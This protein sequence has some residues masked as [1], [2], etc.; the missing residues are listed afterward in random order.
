[1]TKELVVRHAS[2]ME[3]QPTRP[4]TALCACLL[5]AC[6]APPGAAPDAGSA[7]DA[8]TATPTEF[9][10]TVTNGFG[11]GNYPAGA[12]V[13]VWSDHDPRAQIVTRWSGDV[14]LLSDS[15][16]WHTSL[17]MPAR[18]VSL[19]AELTDS[20][21]ELVE[22]QFRGRDRLKTVRY[23]I[24]P[25]P[26]GMVHITHGTGGS[27]AII[28]GIEAGYIARVLVHAGYGVWATDAEEVDTGDQDGN[29]KIRWNVR[30]TEDNVDF[31]NLTQIIE[32]FASRELI[33]QGTPQFIVGM[34]NGGAFA[35]VAGS[36]LNLSAAVVYCA[37]GSEGVAATTETP[38]AWF[39]CEQ[40]ENEQV[41]NAK[42]ARNHEALTARGVPSA[43]S[44]HG[45]SPLYDQRFARIVGIDAET[46]R[47]IAS[48]LRAGG[49]TDERDFL[50]HDGAD[51]E[52]RVTAAPSDYPVIS[53]LR[54]RLKGLEVLH[55]LR[56]L[57]SNHRLYDDYARRTLTFLQAHT[58]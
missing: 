20:S 11:S 10:L 21:F 16:E 5:A 31:A 51:I 18:D 3:T 29:D 26:V 36:A 6:A 19:Q 47:A 44:S 14:A 38:T 39:L 17:V 22:A 23:H 49:H 45:P 35:L 1:L 53:G 37:S 54:P 30:P 57:R 50:L 32:Q 41:D 46:S 9:Q 33:R 43:L 28:E 58:P 24:P 15:G 25:N 52:R 2:R 48:E 40:D 8:S 34:S 12:T 55:Q 42:S 4:L 7:S 56:V 27:G 13:H